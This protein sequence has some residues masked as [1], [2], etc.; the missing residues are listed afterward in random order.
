MEDEYG[1]GLPALA[2]DSGATYMLDLLGVKN[3]RTLCRLLFFGRAI[4]VQFWG[5]DRGFYLH[6][7]SFLNRALCGAV[8]IGAAIEPDAYCQAL[9][10]RWRV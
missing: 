8:L 9:Q 5:D 10:D 7:C 4:L 2:R 6:G 3:L 1:T